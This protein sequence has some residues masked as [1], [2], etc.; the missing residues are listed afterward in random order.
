MKYRAMMKYY[1]KWRGS[2]YGFIYRIAMGAAAMF[3]LVIL[4]IVFPFGNKGNIR[5]ALSKWSAVLKWAVGR[6]YM[7]LEDR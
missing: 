6:Q 2:A 7:A 4:V 3:R 5:S 1:L